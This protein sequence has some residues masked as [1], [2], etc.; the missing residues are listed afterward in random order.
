MEFDD[1]NINQLAHRYAINYNP[2]EGGENEQQ[3][4]VF[5]D[6]AELVRPVIERKASWEAR[7]NPKIPQ[8]D[9]ESEFWEALFKAARSYD[10]KIPFMAR[11]REFMGK[12]AVNLIRHHGYFKRNIQEE[13][14]GKQLYYDGDEIK[15]Y[16]DILPSQDDVEGEVL[17][18]EIKR[19]LADYAESNERNGKIIKLVVFGCTNLE[20]A[21]SIGANQY[22]ARTRKIVQRAKASFKALLA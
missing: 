4:Q 20:I 5:H 17:A 11:F 2:T 19:T 6:L 3:R 15:T 10:G 9:F 21:K 16:Y 14:L 22:D 1:D 8:E 13:P 12:A 18:G 7:N